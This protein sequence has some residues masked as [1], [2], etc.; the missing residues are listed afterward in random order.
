M[1]L[2]VKITPQ[3]GV[4]LYL[5][6][7]SIFGDIITPLKLRCIDVVSLFS[8]SVYVSLAFSVVLLDLP[9]VDFTN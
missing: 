9:K 2:G 7:Y 8:H 4:I 3:K 1:I 6:S 5:K